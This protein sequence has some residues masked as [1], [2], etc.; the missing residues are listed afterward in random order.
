MHK[1]IAPI[2][3]KQLAKVTA[4]QRKEPALAPVTSCNS[5]EGRK[6]DSC[7]IIANVHW[8]SLPVGDV[9]VFPS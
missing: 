6:L 1:G 8:R 5:H 9:I 3:F 2:A 7:F 4:C